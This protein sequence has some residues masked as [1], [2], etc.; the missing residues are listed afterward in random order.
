MAEKENKSA[1]YDTRA[2]QRKRAMILLAE[3][4]EENNQEKIKKIFSCWNCTRI[5]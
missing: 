1:Y 5:T 3:A 2:S 4:K